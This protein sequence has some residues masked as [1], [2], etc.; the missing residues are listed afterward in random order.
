LPH[1][2]AVNELSF[3]T[4]SLLDGMRLLFRRDAP[5][6]VPVFER[7]GKKAFHPLKPNLVGTDF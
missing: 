6:Q 7:V 5:Q 2:C 3:E 1:Y 4:K